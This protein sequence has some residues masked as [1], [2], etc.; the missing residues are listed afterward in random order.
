MTPQLYTIRASARTFIARNHPAVF[1]LTIVLLFIAASASLYPITTTTVT[2]ASPSTSIAGFDKKTVDQI[3]SLH[4]SA[5]SAD[6]LVFPSP[7]SNPF[8]EK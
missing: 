5:D 1:I 4:D 8:V 6:K 2:D 7:R 3:K